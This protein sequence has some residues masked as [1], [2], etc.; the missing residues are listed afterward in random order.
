MLYLYSFFVFKKKVAKKFWKILKRPLG[1]L[2]RVFNKKLR[3]FS[4]IFLSETDS[5][6]PQL[7][8][9]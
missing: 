1:G 5:A 7:I 2:H 6:Y 8:E 3:V 9:R 4:G